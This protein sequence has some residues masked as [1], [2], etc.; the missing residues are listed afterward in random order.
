MSQTI[1]LQ[2]GQKNRVPLAAF[3]DSLA[4]FL[5]M[6]RDLDSALSK[7]PRGS[8]IWEVVSLHQ[9]SPPIVGVSPTP[10]ANVQDFSSQVESQVLENARLINAGV[11]PTPFMSHAALNRLGRLANTSKMLG[12]LTV[13]VNG[14][15]ASKREGV[16]TETTLHHVQQLTAIKYSGFASIVGSLDS[17]SVHNGNEFRVWD[18][19]SGKPVRCKFKM[20]QEEKIK[21]LLRS[22]VRVSGIVQSNR[23]RVP[24]AMEVEDVNS[25]AKRALPTIEEMSGF[26]RGMTEGK[27]LKEYIEEIADE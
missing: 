14:D 5:G 11:E 23:A 24:V 15:N 26:V 16:I 21:A 27:S 3:I 20:D 9:S 6:L 2:I 8:V 1:F 18:E 10:R 22:R 19:T 25:T 4:N 7:S 12:Q 17:I 13:Y